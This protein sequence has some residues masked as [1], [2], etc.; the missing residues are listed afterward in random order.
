M[1][2]VSLLAGIAA[3]GIASLSV[4]P[5]DG[6]FFAIFTGILF[7]NYY[8]GYWSKL[9]Y[10]KDDQTFSF[11]F[12]PDFL[13]L[14]SLLLLIFLSCGCEHFFYFYR[15]VIYVN[16]YMLDMLGSVRIVIVCRK[17]I[18][19]LSF[20]IDIYLLHFNNWK[21]SLTRLN[22]IIF[23]FVKLHKFEKLTCLQNLNY[24][25]M[26]KYEASKHCYL[27]AIAPK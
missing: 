14:W 9:L 11:G 17:K 24:S 8:W 12:A 15:M 4:N 7:W 6:R 18:I 1:F 20:I 10:I 25:K 21:T 3:G 26:Q 19:I 27:N 13:F 22:G 2:Y 16:L 5:F 23:L